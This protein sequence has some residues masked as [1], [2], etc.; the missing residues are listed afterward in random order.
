MGEI[1]PL[2]AA[3]V[4]TRAKNTR[5]VQQAF[6]NNAWTLDV[7]GELSFSAHMQVG[8]LC[9]VIATVARNPNAPDE[10]SWP[11]NSSSSYTAKSVYKRLCM[12]L[13]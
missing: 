1:A 5:T 4:S 9:L 3:L 12:G 6:E 8:N 13:E 2:L 7:E 11:A 10:F